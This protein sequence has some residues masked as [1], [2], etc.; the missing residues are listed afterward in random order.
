IVYGKEEVYK[1]DIIL[2]IDPPTKEEIDLMV[3]G[4]H[5]FSAIQMTNLTDS[6]IKQLSQKKI[7]AIAYEFLKDQEDTLSIIR[8]MSEIAGRSAVLIGAEYL[9]NPHGGK[10]ELLGGVSGIPPSEVVIIGAGTV[11]EYA[12][13]TAVALGANV[14]VFDNS[15]SKLRR[16][17]N[18]IGI[19]LF[20]SI[21]QPNILGKA[22]LTC[23]LAIGALRSDEGRSPN[24]V[25]EEMVSKMKAGAVIV[26][27]S[28]DQG[29]CFETSEVTTHTNP[30]VLKHDVI[31][32]GVPNIPSRVARTASYALSNI[33]TPI[34]IDIAESGGFKNYFWENNV[35]RNGVYIYKGTLVKRHIGERFNLKYKD[36]D[37]LIGAH[38]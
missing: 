32:Y 33:F 9:G 29:G 7:T 4:Q 16:L 21:I 37:L 38:L 2:K 23:D 19:P 10:G 31:H 26:D 15:L 24:V 28:I 11:G 35:I 36:I 25:S 8:S 27:V 3:P 17:Q 30:T 20:T 12:A 22:L 1:S 18:H 13:R 5:L 6:Y 14:K 34:L